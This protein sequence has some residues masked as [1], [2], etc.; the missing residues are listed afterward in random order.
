MSGDVIKSFLE[1]INTNK[2]VYYSKSF[3]CPCEKSLKKGFFDNTTLNVVCFISVNTSVFQ[4]RFKKY[5]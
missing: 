3:P 2:L 4:Y 5:S 1:R